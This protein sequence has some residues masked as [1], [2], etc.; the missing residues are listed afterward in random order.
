MFV[1]IIGVIREKGFHTGEE[2]QLTTRMHAGQKRLW[3]LRVCG[4][5]RRLK[6]IFHRVILTTY[7][8]V[9]IK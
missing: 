5:R 3:T 7:Q 8:Y 6:L 4:R 9:L 1:L 2:C